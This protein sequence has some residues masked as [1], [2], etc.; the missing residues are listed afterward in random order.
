MA[1]LGLGWDKV[2]RRSRQLL[3]YVTIPTHPPPPLWSRDGHIDKQASKCW[4]LAVEGDVVCYR[5]HEVGE[6]EL[7]VESGHCPQE[8]CLVAHLQHVEADLSRISPGAK[9]PPPRIS[10]LEKKLGL[11]V[12][13]GRV[14]P[15]PG[16]E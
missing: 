9:L 3:V 11:F 2:Q 15:F 5:W 4:I 14:A 16:S 1:L 6:E 8:H 13:Q 12:L 10:L 7:L